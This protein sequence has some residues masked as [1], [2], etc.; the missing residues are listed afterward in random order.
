MSRQEPLENGANG[1]RDTQGRFA[2]GN[3]GG[4]GNPFVRQ[5]AAI[6]NALMK[7][8]SPDEI[9]EIAAALVSKAKAG[10]VRAAE[11]LFNRVLGP[12]VAT[13]VLER[14]DEMEKLVNDLEKERERAKNEHQQ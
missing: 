1:G 9:A 5:V 14:L 4:P 2:K 6:R 13:D 10:D 8:V 11:I 7:A 12:P 3:R